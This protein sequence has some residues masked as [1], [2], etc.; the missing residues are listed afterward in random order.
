MCFHVCACADACRITQT[1]NRG[2]LSMK[3]IG[4]VGVAVFL[5]CQQMTSRGQACY[6]K[7]LPDVLHVMR[8]NTSIYIFNFSPSN[9]AVRSHYTNHSNKIHHTSYTL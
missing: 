5:S 3:F 4:C 7:T 8:E 9:K 2:I 1:N 6:N